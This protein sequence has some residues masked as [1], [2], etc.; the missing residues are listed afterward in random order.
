MTDRTYPHGVPCWID[1]SHPD[2]DAAMRFYGDLFGWR[3]SNA[4]PPG[5][6]GA[7]F[8]ATL[9]GEDVAAV[10]PGAGDDGWISYIACDDADATAALVERAGGRVLD[11]PEDAGPGAR[12]ATCADPQGAIF[13]LWQARGRLGAQ[14][15]NVPGAW[16]FSDLHTPDPAAA[17][18]FYGEVFGWQVDSDLGAGMIR[19]PGYGEHLE[20]TVYPDI[21]EQQAFAPEG[22]ADVVAGISPS[23]EGAFWSI[24]FTVANRDETAALAQRLG[25]TIASSTE[26]DWTRECVIVDPQG[27]RFTASELV[28]PE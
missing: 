19:L 9:D 15:V 11:P 12:A 7:Y 14:A 24:R 4:M 8:I 27:A 13:R 5:A 21:R 26:T 18:A 2:T 22:F 10:A 3:F 20:A 17:L 6:P 25:G 16:N 23:A 1:L 28:M